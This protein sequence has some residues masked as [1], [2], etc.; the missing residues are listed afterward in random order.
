ML[1]LVANGLNQSPRPVGD[2]LLAPAITRRLVERFARPAPS[3]AGD[4]A[5]LATLTAREREVFGLLARGMSNTEIADSLVIGEAT[6]KSHVTAVLA[7]LELRN[8]A[9]AVVL[10][11][12]SGLIRAS[13]SNR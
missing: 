1:D 8:R 12:E 9:Q 10:A 2:A 4:A 11:Y 7:K 6:V 3:P 5:A 13:G